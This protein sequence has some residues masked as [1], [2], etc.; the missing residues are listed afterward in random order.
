MHSPFLSFFIVG[1]IEGVVVTL[2]IYRTLMPFEAILETK[3]YKLSQDY[4]LTLMVLIKMR[5]L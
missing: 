4:K 5:A 3:V 1:S 2:E